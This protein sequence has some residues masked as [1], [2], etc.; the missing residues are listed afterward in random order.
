[1]RLVFFGTPR[2]AEIVLQHLFAADIRPIALVANPDRPVG[3]KK[4]L[5]PPPTVQ[6]VRDTCPPKSVEVLQPETLDA[7]FISRLASLKPDV[8]VIAAYAKII[9]LDLVELPRLGTLG[10]H[11]SL[12]PTLRGASPIASAILTGAER[13]GATIYRMDEKMDHGP[14]LAARVLK[15]ADLSAID[16][17]T[18][19]T[20]LAEL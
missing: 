14:I 16:E 7:A 1:M 6:L 10:V 18:L 13:T 2:F 5:T 4:V 15:D 20:K 17:P 12:L 19:E 9:P 8:S 3:R 11:P